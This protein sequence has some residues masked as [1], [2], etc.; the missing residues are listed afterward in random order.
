MSAWKTASFDMYDAHISCEALPENTSRHR[1]L[2]LQRWCSG[3]QQ[4][5]LQTERLG[6][7]HL[8]LGPQTCTPSL[9]YKA[10][11]LQHYKTVSKPQT[12]TICVQSTPP[13]QFPGHKATPPLAPP[14]ASSS[15]NTCPG[16]GIALFPDLS[17]ALF[18]V[19]GMGGISGTSPTTAAHLC[20]L[21]IHGAG[22]IF[23]DGL[24]RGA[25]VHIEA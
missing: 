18:Q 2:V 19:S 6:R 15:G 21:L 23:E 12:R 8:D 24:C 20:T 4:Q 16:G 10:L 14:D 9:N 11:S 1:A 17:P 25:G 5:W 22:R 7:R 3:T 13:K